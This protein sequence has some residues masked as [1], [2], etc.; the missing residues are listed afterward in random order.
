[1]RHAQQALAAPPYE[2][3]PERQKLCVILSCLLHDADDA[4]YFSRRAGE[5]TFASLM[6]MDAV[7]DAEVAA[8]VDRLISLVSTRHNHNSGSFCRTREELEAIA[9]PERFAAYDGT[10]ASVID[11]FYD[12]LLH[13]RLTPEMTP[14]EYL[15]RIS[16]ERHQ[17][18]VDYVLGVWRAQ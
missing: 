11:H 12:K 3:V 7:G 9:T 2:A 16:R 13:L 10:S 14:S 1:M 15:Q 17:V 6:V 4:K 8:E 18:M 5:P